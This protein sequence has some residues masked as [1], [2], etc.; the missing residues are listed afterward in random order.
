MDKLRLWGHYGPKWIYQSD[1]YGIRKWI[2]FFLFKLIG[3]V[4]MNSK[5]VG[6]KRADYIDN[7]DGERVA[8]YLEI[9]LINKI[10]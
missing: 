8:G 5:V 9:R 7:D 4:N 10:K 2:T 3:F 6:V 1:V